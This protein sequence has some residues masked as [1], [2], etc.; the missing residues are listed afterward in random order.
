[1]LALFPTSAAASLALNTATLS[2]CLAAS[3]SSSSST[4]GSQLW[5]LVKVGPPKTAVG[6]TYTVFVLL[7]LATG[8]S[9]V[10]RWCRECTV[11]HCR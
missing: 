9:W 3:S 2:Q 8:E 6:W 7:Y 4:T 1:M 10:G 5:E 11:M